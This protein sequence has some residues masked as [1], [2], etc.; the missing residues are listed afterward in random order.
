MFFLN[1]IHSSYG[2]EPSSSDSNLDS[3]ALEKKTFKV[4]G[5]GNITVPYLDQEITLDGEL[6]DAIWQQANTVSLNLVNSP[7]QNL[8]SPINTQAKIIENGKLPLYC[9]YCR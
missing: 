6:D 5:S 4:I 3:N 9:F 1:P 8:P 7:W 2:Q